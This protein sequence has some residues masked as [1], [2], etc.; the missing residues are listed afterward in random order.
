MWE[1]VDALGSAV[2][3]SLATVAAVVAYRLYKVESER[4][5]RANEQLA[6]HQAASV[7]AWIANYVDPLSTEDDD[8]D[9]DKGDVPAL[10]P[11]EVTELTFIAANLSTLPIYRLSVH[12]DLGQ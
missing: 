10:A 9:E 6:R 3:A 2:S 4:D 1:I 7:G 12:Y 5:R 11:T 8:D